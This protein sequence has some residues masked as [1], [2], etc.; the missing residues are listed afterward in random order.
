MS[1]TKPRLASRSCYRSN[2]AEDKSHE[3]YYRVNVFIP[4]LDEVI[5]DLE[6]RFLKHHEQ[7]FMLSQ[8]I[9]S[10]VLSTTWEEVLPV[11]NKYSGLLTAILSALWKENILFGSSI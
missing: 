8:L 4:M 6:A 3:V 7:S 5:C 2:A 1:I 11:V 10:D 9:P